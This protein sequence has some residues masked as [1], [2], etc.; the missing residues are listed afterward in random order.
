MAG[1]GFELKKLFRD[2]KGYFHSIK[3]YTVASIVTE[4]P[5][6]L[7]ILMLFVMKFLLSY[8]GSSYREQE[9]YVYTI[10]YIMIFSLIFSNTVLMFVDRS[11]SDAIYNRQTRN[12]MPL[13][14]SAVFWLV[15]IGG[16]TAIIYLLLIPVNNLYRV[17]SLIVFCLMLM[18]WVEV[19]FLS[20]VKQYT[21]VLVGFI[22][23]VIVA[24]ISG[25]LLLGYTNM[26]REAGALI[27]TGLGFFVLFI[28]LL[29]QMMIVY[30]KGK[31]GLFRLFPGLD[32]YKIL[33]G[34]GVFMSLGFFTHNFV[35]WGSDLH[36]EIWRY[37]VVCL[38]YDVPTFFAT[39][40]I[41]PMLVL[42]TVSVETSFYEKYREYFDAI[43][44]GGTLEDIKM[45]KK[46]M[47][48]V[49]FRE[50]FRMMEIQL[51]VSIICATFLGNALR[52]CG[53]DDEQIS[54]FRILCFGYC[55]F[56]LAKCL[57]IMLL[58]FEDRKGALFGSALFVVCSTLFSFIVIRFD[59]VYWGSGFL[60]AAFIT[61]IYS[62]LRLRYFL[63]KLEHK[64]FLRQPL[65]YVEE[66][67]I[68]TDIACAADEQEKRFQKRMQKMQQERRRK[69]NHEY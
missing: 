46:N 26:Q 55:L 9:I 58:Y 52:R 63:N 57:I 3:A 56:G 13:F 40:T 43:Q 2:E 49:A 4:G 11:I 30:P 62:G 20:A 42:F 66:N 60:I 5:M 69:N 44:Y 68:F 27:A 8:Y 65:F 22:A 28:M 7:N 47:V 59:T 34:I 38:K 35:A 39:L 67:G 16:I 53:L 15:I 17:I 1:I 31:V 6:L 23:A 51:L 54:I 21:K 14:Y 36:N 10:T 64:V 50:I 18:I 29:Q 41:C 12:I 19:S 37:G 48:K 61:V 24:I 25:I 45:A 33:I 32:E